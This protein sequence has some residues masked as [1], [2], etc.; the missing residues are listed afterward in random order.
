MRAVVVL[1]TPRTPVRIQ[2]C[3]TRPVANALVSVRT[4]A[5]CPMRS[6]NVCG[7]YLRASTRYGPVTA[8]SGSRPA[9]SDE[10]ASFIKP[11]ANASLGP[12]RVGRI[13]MS[14]LGGRLTSDPNRSSLGLL[15]SGP[16]PVGE[17]LVPR[18]PPG[19]YIGPTGSESKHGQVV[20]D[21]ASRRGNAVENG[22][23]G[24]SG[25]R[26]AA[27]ELVGRL[28]ALGLRFHRFAV[29]LYR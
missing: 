14:C 17:W 24:R 11:P 25:W 8:A 18:Q 12:G 4:M 9:D 29:L 2:A 19:I 15:P 10:R 26:F 20:I 5:S 13:R 21:A 28:R 7:R 23:Q 22:R 16:D 1:P 6:S 27:I 3:G